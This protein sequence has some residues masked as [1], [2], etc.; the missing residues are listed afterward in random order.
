MSISTLAMMAA[1]VQTAAAVPLP[2]KCQAAADLF[3]AQSCYPLLKNRP[4]GGPMIAADAAHGPHGGGF[5]CC[6]KP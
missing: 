6:E 1:L 3:C 4:C 2:P 5:K